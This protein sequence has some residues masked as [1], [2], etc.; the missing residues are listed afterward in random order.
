[1][2]TALKVSFTRLINHLRT[3][4]NIVLGNDWGYW[5]LATWYP[6]STLLG[7]PPPVTWEVPTATLAASDGRRTGT[8]Y[9]IT[10]DD[11]KFTDRFRLNSGSRQS[12]PQIRCTFQSPQPY[13]VFANSLPSSTPHPDWTLATQPSP[14]PALVS[15]LQCQ[16]T[17]SAS[18][19]TT[20][21]S[22]PTT[23]LLRTG[24][25]TLPPWQQTRVRHLSTAPIGSVIRWWH[26]RLWMH[27]RPGDASLH[28]LRRRRSQRWTGKRMPQGIVGPRLIGESLG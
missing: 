17:V 7:A 8:V 1:M 27:R 15:S 25:L 26:T 5:L 3:R 19:P 21:C 2:K 20:R 12:H 6:C 18:T 11:D 4:T 28:L 16:T 14:P 22:L 9:T 13:P 10:T 24:V 23:G